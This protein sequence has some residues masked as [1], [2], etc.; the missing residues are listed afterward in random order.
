M[1][2]QAGAIFGPYTN[3]IRL[4]FHWSRTSVDVANNKSTIYWELRVGCTSSINFSAKKNWSCTVNGNS[5][6]GTY[7]GGMHGSN[8]T[9]TAASGTT[10]ITHNSDGTKSFAVSAVFGIK[11][12]ITSTGQMLNNISL[13][14]SDTLDI[15]PRIST[16]TAANGTLGTAQT[17]TVTRQADSF[18]HTVTYGCGS[19]SGTICTKSTATDISWT[20][21]LSLAGQNTTGTAVAVTLRI[22]TFTGDTS[23]GTSTTTISCAIP[24]SVKPSLSILSVLDANGYVTKYG[25]YIQGKSA[26][27]IKLSAAGSYGSTIKSYRTTVDGSTY[28]AAAI[29]TSVL[30]SA[31]TLTITTT[32]TDSRG[33]TATATKQVS[34][35]AYAE[36]KIT[37]LKAVRCT[38]DGTASSSGEYLK[39]VFS[40]EVT[41][42]G[43]KNSAVYSIQ[44]KGVTS[45][46]YLSTILADYDGDYT[47]ADGSY[48]FAASASAAFNIRIV[49]ADD[50]GSVSKDVIGHASGGLF[51]ILA[52]GLGFAFGK[53][54]ELEDCLDIAWNLRVRKDAVI[55]GQLTYGI[56]AVE[57]VDTCITSGM[58][59]ADG[60]TINKPATAEGYVQA[61]YSDGGMCYQRYTAADGHAYERLQS[62]DG[63][64]GDW[65][66]TYTSGIWT[67][68]KRP[69]GECICWGKTYIQKIDIITAI[70]GMYR[71]DVQTLP[72][73][74]PVVFA[75]VPQ[76]QYEYCTT[77]GVGA[78]LWQDGPGTTS[79]MPPFYLLRPTATAKV[80][81][82]GY[83]YITAYGRWK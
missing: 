36:P 1:A 65:C 27:T 54:A 72:E 47:V 13:S 79:T 81:A 28:T 2:D 44:R 14:G 31:G 37:A 16:L 5:Y 25:A 46:V 11:I 82:E 67:Y 56:P 23:L 69:D 77:M 24:A 21:P 26:L 57:D 7:S 83:M 48:I 10:E 6:S 30:K 51:S 32:V 42:L 19:E 61:A 3:G 17:L 58:Y 39:A 40:A 43:D 52:K 50:F 33:R 74:Y 62:E 66:G 34:V 68:E 53:K 60:D 76:V 4:E 71:S 9:A 59:Y 20:P 78:V 35:L 8:I 18:T 80:Q 29:E 73:K 55:D 70:G 12:T 75:E 38:S 41:P 22:E 15:I 64:W 63:T 45:D 49:A